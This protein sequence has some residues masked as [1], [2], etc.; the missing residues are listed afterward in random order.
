MTVYNRQPLYYDSEVPAF[1]HDESPHTQC[2]EKIAADWMVAYHKNGWGPWMSK[3]RCTGLY[4]KAAQLVKQ[5]GPSSGKMLDIGCR[6][7]E[8]F[9]QFQNFDCYGCDISLNYLREGK[10]RGFEVCRATAEDL[11]YFDSTFDLVSCTDVLEHVLDLNQSIREILRVLKPGGT[12]MLRVPEDKSLMNYV[13]REQPYDFIHLRLFDPG[14][15]M[16]TFERVFPCE[17]VHME[18]DQKEIFAVIRK[19]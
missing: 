1:F 17:I 2:C 18:Q 4:Q 5:H 12:I 6:H 19:P 7:G 9:P 16:L 15:V 10:R 11:P 14:V 8:V 3:P 13:T